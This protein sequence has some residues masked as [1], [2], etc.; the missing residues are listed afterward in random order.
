MHA[1]FELWYPIAKEIRHKN[2]LL[3][4]YILAYVKYSFSSALQRPPKLL[5]TD[6]R[7][8]VHENEKLI[9]S[10]RPDSQNVEKQQNSGNKVIPQKH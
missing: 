8:F 10:Y 3:P 2:G 1:L 4:V 7:A 9:N 5:G 6:L